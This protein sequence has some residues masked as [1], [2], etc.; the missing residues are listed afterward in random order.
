M[1]LK[2]K[3]FD[4]DS[5]TERTLSRKAKKAKKNAETRQKVEQEKLN[6]VLAKESMSAEAIA[7]AAEQAALEIAELEVRAQTVDDFAFFKEE[8]V[9]LNFSSVDIIW[10]RDSNKLTGDRLALYHKL[11]HQDGILYIFSVFSQFIVNM[12]LYGNIIYVYSDYTCL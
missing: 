8:D 5:K 6:E 4:G 9:V 1:I 2:E 7:H 11:L 10:I 3:L 12:C